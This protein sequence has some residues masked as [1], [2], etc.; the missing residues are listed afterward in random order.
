[1]KDSGILDVYNKCFE[2]LVNCMGVSFGFGIG[3]LGNIEVNF[4]FC[5]EK[6]F[7]KVN[8]FFI[9]FVLVNMIG[10]F[11]FIEF[12]IK[13]FNFFS[14]M[15]CVVGIYVIIEVVKII[16]F[17][18]VDRMFVVGVEFI[19]CFVGIGGFV[20]IK[21]FFIRNDEFKKVL[22]FFDKDCNGFVMGEGVGVL[23]FEEYESVKKREVK[24]YVEFVGYGES[25]DVNYIIVLVFEGE[26]VF[27]V[28]KMVLE[29]VKVEVGY[30]NVYGISMY[31]NDWYESIVLKNVFGFKEKVLFVSFIKG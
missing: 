18:G 24:I 29:M 20:S 11:I 14:V 12:G 23:V 4:I 5:F 15:V 9:I 30:V 31:Y 28:M 17:N 13:G 3:G 25:G 6:G 26:G 16:L 19:I 22:R 8:F 27:R 1:M 7:R 2:E 21:V 10:G